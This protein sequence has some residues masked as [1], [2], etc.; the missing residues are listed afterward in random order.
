MA[1]NA[2]EIAARAVELLLKSIEDEE[3]DRKV[4]PSR[5]ILEA[6]LVMRESA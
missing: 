4:A 2:S 5:V 6:T 3:A 1:Q